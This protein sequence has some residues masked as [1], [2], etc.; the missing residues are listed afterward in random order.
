[1]TAPCR[2]P[3]TR[4]VDSRGFVPGVNR[5]TLLG[6]FEFYRRRRHQCVVCSARFTTYEVTDEQALR[7]LREPC[8]VVADVLRGTI[9]ELEQVCEGKEEI[10]P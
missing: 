7:M 5:G 9:A 6:S 4:V 3:L 1:M 2:H 8:R 10:A